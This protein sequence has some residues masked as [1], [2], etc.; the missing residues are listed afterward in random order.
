MTLEKVIGKSNIIIQ[1]GE[2][3]PL[4]EQASNWDYFGH[5]PLVAYCF[6]SQTLRDADRENNKMALPPI[7]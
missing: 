7:K 5:V 4:I 6:R 3:I 1:I 2:E